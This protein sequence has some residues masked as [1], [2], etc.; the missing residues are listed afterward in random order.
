VEPSSSTKP[1]I[2]GMDVHYLWFPTQ[3]RMRRRIEK[4]ADL[5]LAFRGQLFSINPFR[6][7]LVYEKVA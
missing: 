4:R 3:G 5:G 2:G 1:A 6:C 7:G